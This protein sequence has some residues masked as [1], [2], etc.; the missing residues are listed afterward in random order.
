MLREFYD[1]PCPSAANRLSD[2]RPRAEDTLPA[3]AGCL[4]RRLGA[5]ARRASSSL[6]YLS[7]TSAEEVYTPGLRRRRTTS[8]R[9]RG[10]VASSRASSCVAPEAALPRDVVVGTSC[11][12]TLGLPH[13][14][15]RSGF[16]AVSCLWVSEKT[17]SRLLVNRGDG[18]LLVGRPRSLANLANTKTKCLAPCYGGYII[19]TTLETA[20]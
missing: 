5:V 11:R 18:Y 16:Y 15:G 13:L 10:T 9:R 12:G 14:P 2:D 8:R 17:P 7:R 4:A 1:S 20:G 6:S 3:P 19:N